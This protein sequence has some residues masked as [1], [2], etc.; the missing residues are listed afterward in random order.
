MAPFFVSI[1]MISLHRSNFWI[2]DAIQFTHSAAATIV[3][4]K[5][6][7]GNISHEIQVRDLPRLCRSFLVKFSCVIQ[8]LSHHIH[9]QNA[10]H[11]LSSFPLTLTDSPSHS[12][13]LSHSLIYTHYRVSYVLCFCLSFWIICHGS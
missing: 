8:V 6:T 12:L 4:K 1:P 3:M 11:A 5:F 2:A 13:S 7:Y 9:K 10:P